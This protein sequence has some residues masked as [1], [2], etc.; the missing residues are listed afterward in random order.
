MIDGAT[1]LFNLRLFNHLLSFF[2]IFAF[3]GG[4]FSAVPD[5]LQNQDES[6]AGKVKFSNRYDVHLRLG[7]RETGASIVFGPY[8]VYESIYVELQP[9]REL[10][11]WEQ[12]ELKLYGD[13]LIQSVKPEFLFVEFTEYPLSWIS[14][15]IKTKYPEFYTNFNLTPE[16]NLLHSLGAGYQEPWSMSIF[17]GKLGTFWDLNE[18]YDLIVAASGAAGLV[19]TGG[20][21]QI[22]DNYLVRSNWMR[23]E[24]KLKGEGKTRISSNYWDIKMG[25]RW[26]GITNLPNTITF[27]LS[28]LRTNESMFDWGLMQNTSFNFEIQVPATGINN[29]ISRL[30]IAFGKVF[31]IKMFLAGIKIGYGFEHRQLYD[32]QMGA[33]SAEKQRI[34]EIYFQPMII[35]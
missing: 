8:R 11:F 19:A 31:P 18:N 24:W 10:I 17:L 22:F 7:T 2:L 32:Q 13:L 9:K 25:Y 4:L 20:L 5:T 26:Y 21:Y 30:Y 16:F 3:I 15:A 12:N 27:S 33:F 29:D 23:L 1:S 34:S 14:A 6:T 35:F 28:R